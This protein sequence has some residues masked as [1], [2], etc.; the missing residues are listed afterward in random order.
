MAR[1]AWSDRT[2]RRRWPPTSTRWPPTAAWPSAW[3]RPR[4]AMPRAHLG[5]RGRSAH[6]SAVARPAR[7]VPECELGELCCNCADEEGTGG[8]GGRGAPPGARRGLHHDL[9]PAHRAALPAGGRRRHRLRPRPRR[10]RAVP[11]HARHP[12]DDVPRQD[13]DDAAVRGLRHRRPDQRALQV[14]AR[15]RHATA[16]PSPSTCPP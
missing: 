2:R 1:T 5:A 9:R 4:A 10:P 7:P 14:P 13:L 11:V 3:A 15:A 8:E 16:S 12:R 6:A